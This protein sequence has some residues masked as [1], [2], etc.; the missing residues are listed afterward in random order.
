MHIHA[1]FEKWFYSNDRGE[2]AGHLAAII[3]QF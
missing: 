2:H 3:L 1:H